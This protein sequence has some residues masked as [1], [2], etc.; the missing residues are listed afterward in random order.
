MGTQRHEAVRPAGIKQGAMYVGAV[1]DRV[2]IAE[3]L[4]KARAA[5]DVDNFFAADG[6]EHHHALNQQC[7]P[8][9][10]LANAKPVQRRQRI[11]RNL[12]P[13]AGLAE[14]GNL[15]E[16]DASEALLRKRQRRREPA[17]AAAGNRDRAGIARFHQ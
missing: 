13:D 8:L 1:G 6:V 14:F 7:A 16:N 5:F 10:R 4:A 3:P 11:R 12:K 17:Y 15:F 9:D 2:R